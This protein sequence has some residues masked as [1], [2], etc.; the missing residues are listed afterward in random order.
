MTK[1]FNFTT[2]ELEQFIE[3]GLYFNFCMSHALNLGYAD[4]VRSK[5]DFELKLGDYTA[6]FLGKD[7]VFEISHNEYIFRVIHC[8]YTW[9]NLLGET[10]EDKI[11]T[12][13]LTAFRSTKQ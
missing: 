1:E 9:I 3:E 2:D 8:G 13:L 11:K 7:M 5:E 4:K 12:E 6:K 10:D